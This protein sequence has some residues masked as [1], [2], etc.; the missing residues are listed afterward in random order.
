MMSSPN[1][2]HE[3]LVTIAAEQYTKYQPLLLDDFVETVTRNKGKENA[4]INGDAEGEQPVTIPVNR[5]V[6]CAT[7]MLQSII[8]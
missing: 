6:K 5:W 7:G 3:G 4:H 2:P 1:T 8:R